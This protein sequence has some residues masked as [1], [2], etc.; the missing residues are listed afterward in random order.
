ML[1]VYNEAE[2][3]GYATEIT[4]YLPEG[5]DYVEGEFN[6]QYG[7]EYEEETRKVK[8]EVYEMYKKTEYQK[9]KIW[10]YLMRY[11]IEMNRAVWY[12][13]KIK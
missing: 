9:D 2:V 4:D 5:L 11:T 10:E 1:R 6:E 8:R 13:E 12:V 7:W 3:N